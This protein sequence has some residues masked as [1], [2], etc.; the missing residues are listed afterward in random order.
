MSKPVL[1]ED[2]D[3]V[4]ILTLNRPDALNA[5]SPSLFIELREHVDSIA[6]SHDD[7][8]CVILQG[9]GRSFSAGNDLKAL[10]KGEAPPGE[11]F[12]ADTI[13]ALEAMPQPVIAAVQG[14]CYTGAL[15]L[16]LGC[17]LLIC[18]ESAQFFDTH[19]KWGLSSTWGMSQRLPR[20]IGYL[21]AK[22]VMYTSQLIS[23][24]EAE[25]IGLANRCVP[26]DKLSSTV[27]ELATAIVENS[28]FSLRTYKMLMR[29]GREMLLPDALDFERKNSPGM[30]PDT[31][32]RL[33][34]FF[35]S[36]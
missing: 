35:K 21:K 10:Q 24:R 2:K 15:E 16:V 30:G 33:E 17:D 8:G 9:S 4:S 6:E 36:K 18:S 12:Q 13:D 29:E 7:I 28:W 31:I 5:L 23:G 19:A 11:H 1:R 26:D 22:E 25:T 27:M 20:R 14:H 32:E 34:K 3:G